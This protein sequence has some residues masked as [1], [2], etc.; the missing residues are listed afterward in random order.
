MQCNIFLKVG[1]ESLRNVIAMS[2][3]GFS[4]TIH[5]E[6]NKKLNMMAMC[7][8]TKNNKLKYNIGKINK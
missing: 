8:K 1:T 2:R 5:D 3:V 6:R 7:V 4:E